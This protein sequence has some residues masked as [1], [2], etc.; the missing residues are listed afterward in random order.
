[1][2]QDISGE[3]LR[4]LRLA[5]GMDVAVLA[6][7]V[8]LS[9]AQLLQLENDQHSLFYTPAI[10][11]HAARKVLAHLGSSARELGQQPTAATELHEKPEPVA[12]GSALETKLDFAHEPAPNAKPQGKPVITA[13]PL[14]AP[15]LPE[16]AARAPETVHAPA[17]AGSQLH[18]ASTSRR[19]SRSVASAAWTGGLVLAALL[20]VWV[21]T[22][23][24]P[25]TPSTPSAPSPDERL[26]SHDA[27]GPEPPAVSPPEPS[28]RLAVS[29]AMAPGVAVKAQQERDLVALAP[30]S[31][32]TVP[33]APSLTPSPARPEDAPPCP[34]MSA[35]APAFALPPAVAQGRVIHLTS[36]VGQVVCVLDGAGKL[37]PHRL[38]PDQAKSIAGP[39]P[40]TVQAPSLS[41]LQVYFQGVRLAIPANAQD[42]VRLF[43]SP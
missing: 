22:K 21:L 3:Q 13:V 40:W 28:S 10:R 35:A 42:Q 16:Q 41:Q 36:S 12:T 38:E 6:R 7:R 24:A 11:R 33:M 39:P 17:G 34:D 43:E 5:A 1:M 15:D 18:R 37:K 25:S 32:L 23:R 2:T 30:A 26:A 14:K 19:R 29:G 31:S 9:T 20:S 4:A 8:S 27:L